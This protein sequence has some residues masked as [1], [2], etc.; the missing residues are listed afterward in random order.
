MRESSETISFCQ[1]PTSRSI[2]HGM[3]WDENVQRWSGRANSVKS[4]N[5]VPKAAMR[6]GALANQMLLEKSVSGW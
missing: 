6:T 1:N 5:V 3:E 4:Q 2:F